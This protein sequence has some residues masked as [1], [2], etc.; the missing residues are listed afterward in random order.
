MGI[1]IGGLRTVR[2]I[3][4]GWSESEPSLTFLYVDGEHMIPR[5]LGLKCAL[6]S[7]CRY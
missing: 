4:L 6:T 3:E 5:P 1:A 2:A 7:R